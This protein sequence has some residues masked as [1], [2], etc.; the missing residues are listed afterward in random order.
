MEKFIQI[1]LVRIILLVNILFIQSEYSYSVFGQNH[2]ERYN[3]IDVIHYKFNVALNDSTNDIRVKAI[4]NI[5]FKANLE[6]FAL[7]LKNIDGDSFGMFVDD[8]KE[9]NTT[10]KFKHVNNQIEVFADKF[11][12]GE[13]RTFQV[14]YHGI[15][16]DGLII[17]NN[18]FG[19]RV[20]FGDAWPNRAHNWLVTV[21]HPSDKASLEFV[22]QAPSHYSVIANGY[23]VSN[24]IKDD[25]VISHWKTDV[26]LPT[27]VMVIGVGEF[28]VKEYTDNANIPLSTWVYPQ[29]KED[30][31]LDYDEVTKPIS[32]FIEKIGPFPFSKLANVQSKTMFGG[33][34]NASCIFYYENSVSG[35]KNLESLFAHEIAHQWFGDAVSEMNWHHIWLSEGFATYLTGLY[36]ENEH[37]QD[38]FN[39][40]MLNQKKRVLK[41]ASYK[42][43]PVIDT[44]AAVSMRLLNAN[45]YQK[46]AWFLHMLRREVGDVN[47]WKA[48]STFY[49]KYK[50]SNALTEDFQNISEDI[51]GKNLDTFF[52]QWLYGLGHPYLKVDWEYKKKN[53]ILKVFQTQKTT[54]F[55]FPLDIKIVYED[56]SSSVETIFVNKKKYLYSFKSN[57]RPKEIILDPDNW[58]LFESKS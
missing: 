51:S 27:K 20:F 2:F 45:S 15:P 18:K 54:K 44:T 32:F 35:K 14:Y 13:K 55:E 9:N 12:K 10:L 50:Y 43:A 11:T 1:N 41:Y 23:N 16:N 5:E 26:P 7:D 39:K 58:L 40:Y 46:G 3:S 25:Y 4:I 28:A 30:G 52:K 29:N 48:L 34:E 36:L 53:V 49:E 38:E 19:D 33:M 31:F 17:S 47:F 37:G 57:K 42:L 21:D 8:V 24:E 56:G 22:I 6:S